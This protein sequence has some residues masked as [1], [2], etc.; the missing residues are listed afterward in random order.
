M[1]DI[2]GGIGLLGLSVSDQ[3]ESVTVIEIDPL[4]TEAGRRTARLQQLDNVEFIAAPAEQAVFS[5][6]SVERVIVDPPRTGLD[7][8]VVDTLTELGPEIIVYVSC[9]PA[10]FARDAGQFARAGYTLDYFSLWDFY[11]QTVHVEC[12]GRLVRT[13]SG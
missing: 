5:L 2:Y 9:N 3:A 12:M 11:P 4:A 6:P 7:R 13:T 10:T 8:C 1:A